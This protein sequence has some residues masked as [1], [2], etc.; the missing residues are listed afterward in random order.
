M[1]QVFQSQFVVIGD[2]VEHGLWPQ[3]LPSPALLRVRDTKTQQTTEQTMGLGR[4]GIQGR[5]LK[6]L[7]ESGVGGIHGD[8]H[9]GVSGALN[10]EAI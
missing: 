9:E 7:G 2:R 10:V 1:W 5:V 8:G 3:D 6:S 4:G